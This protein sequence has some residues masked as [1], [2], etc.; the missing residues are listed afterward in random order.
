VLAS[1]ADTDGG[2]GHESAATLPE[3]KDVHAVLASD[4]NAVDE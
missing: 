3:P 4:A 1:I 2:S